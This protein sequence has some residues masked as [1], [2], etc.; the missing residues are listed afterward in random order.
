M[1]RLNL[2]EVKKIQLEILDVVS[3]FCEKN[4][5]NYWL[6]SGTL[7]G[8]IRH[9]GYIPWDD[10]IDIGM[11]REDYERFGELFNKTNERYRLVDLENTPDF[12]LA[13]GKIIDTNTVLYEPDKKGDKLAVNIDLFIYDN[14]PDD[15]KLLKKL[16]NKRDRLVFLHYFNRRNRIAKSDSILKKA[17]KE[18]IHLS[19]CRIPSDKFLKEI[20]NNSRRY[21]DKNSKRIGNL[22]STITR[23]AV[24]KK[25]F[26]AF[27]KKPF[28]GKEYSVLIGYDEYLK[29]LF[30]DYM[31]LPPE[32]KRVTHHKFEAYM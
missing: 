22:R 2:E 15:D 26:S 6:D 13:Y 23:L 9:Q 8:A 21:S 17:V 1:R 24:D 32:E 18:S 5:I 16:Y 4:N 19:V 25:C 27:V 30:G 7:L 31:Q 28:E 14:V 3:D 11:L 20:I 10:D 29:Q 12:Y